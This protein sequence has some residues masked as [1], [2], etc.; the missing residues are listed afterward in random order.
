ML[1]RLLQVLFDKDN[2]TVT[3]IETPFWFI[4]VLSGGYI[5]FVTTISPLLKFI[6]VFVLALFLYSLCIAI[7]KLVFKKFGRSSP[8]LKS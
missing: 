1:K 2:W 7:I 6:I 8:Q 3:L 5:L 4:F